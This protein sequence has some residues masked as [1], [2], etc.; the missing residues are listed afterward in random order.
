MH[1]LKVKSLLRE[2]VTV[3]TQHP[4]LAAGCLGWERMAQM[5]PQ[6]LLPTLAML[7]LETNNCGEGYMAG[8]KTIRNAYLQ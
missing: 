6:G 1:E 8:Y 5:K 2:V 3:S 4:V 7:L